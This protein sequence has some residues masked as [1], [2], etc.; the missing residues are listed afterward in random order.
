MQRF[1]K[2][3]IEVLI[4]TPLASRVTDSLNDMNVSGYSV[5]AVSAGRGENGEWNADG[6]IGSANHMTLIICI[7]DPS[8]ADDIV[9][10]VFKIVSRQSGFVTIG[11][12]MVVRPERF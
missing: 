2:K 9:D 12:V 10:N 6:Q 4:E 11:D 7:V 5:I 3:R 1:L 8:V